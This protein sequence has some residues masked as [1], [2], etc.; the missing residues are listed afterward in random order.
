MDRT[1]RNI[2][3]ASLIGL[4][5]VTGAIVFLLG[6]TSGPPPGTTSIDGVIV[7]VQST[8]LT[9]VQSF[10]LRATDGQQLR[11]GLGQL[12]NGVQFPPG[13]LAEHQLTAVP[14]RVW[15]RTAADGGL[16]AIRLEDAP[17]P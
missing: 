12:E 6:G 11:F 10:D 4:V 16:L 1:T 17:A 14:V 3:A 15:Y 5:I 2:F 7:G 8:G 9:N 13:H